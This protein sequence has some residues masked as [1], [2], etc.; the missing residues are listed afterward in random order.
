MAVLATVRYASRSKGSALEDPLEAENASPSG[1]LR[2]L[3]LPAAVG[4]G[5]EVAGRI[6]H[7]EAGDILLLHDSD[8]CVAPGPWRNILGALPIVLQR[9]SSL[10]LRAR[11]V[12]ELLETGKCC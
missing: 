12:G 2:V 3:L 5:H 9:L 8:L 1:P 11:P 6:G 7:P 4:G 10:G